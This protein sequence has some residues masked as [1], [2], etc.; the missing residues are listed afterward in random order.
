MKQGGVVNERKN[1]QLTA[2][3][4]QAGFSLP[5][6]AEYGRIRIKKWGSLEGYPITLALARNVK[7]LD[8]LPI[9][10]DIAT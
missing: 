8:D 6:A 10:Y 9:G 1:S 7:I 5:T 3:G 2:H 4:L